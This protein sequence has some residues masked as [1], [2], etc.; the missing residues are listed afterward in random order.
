[1]STWKSI[2]EAQRDTS[3]QAGLSEQDVRFQSLEIKRIRGRIILANIAGA[4]SL[5]DSAFAGMGAGL[6]ASS[7]GVEPII[8]SAIGLGT[9]VVN[10]LA[11]LIPPTKLSPWARRAVSL[12][13]GGY[14]ITSSLAF[15]GLQEPTLLKGAVEGTALV[16]GSE[17][18]R[19]I[20]LKLTQE[21]KD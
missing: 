3:L 14:G 16:A 15:V 21:S 4:I 10:E 9:A 13:L 17:I 19:R 12:G 8:S 2:I 6:I 20:N 1:M 18:S 7:K 11:K 5:S